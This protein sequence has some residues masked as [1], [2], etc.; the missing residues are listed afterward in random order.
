MI[1]DRFKNSAADIEGLLWDLDN[2]LYPLTDDFADYFNLKIAEVVSE[3][4]VDLPLAEIV[5]LADRSFKEHGY[6]GRIFIER[7]GVDRFALH[8]RIHE[9]ADEGR[10]SR[11]EGLVDEMHQ[12][13]KH[14]AIVTHGSHVW[15]RKVL[16][17]LSLS[18][19][20]PHERIHALE[21]FEYHRKS[22]SRRPFEEGL[23]S[24]N[25]DPAK[26]VMVE[27][28][29]HNLKIPREMGML[30]VLVTQGKPP[31]QDIPSYVDVVCDDAVAFLRLLKRQQGL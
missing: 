26:A 27:D 3:M 5:R 10:L 15:A 30:T 29:V 31:A 17:H 21:T 25:L 16:D 11:T 9:V 24:I 28:M 2:T 13:A 1:S 7:F 22:E 20:F 6:S 18:S 19:W 12:A 4:G 8:H 14:H 23:A